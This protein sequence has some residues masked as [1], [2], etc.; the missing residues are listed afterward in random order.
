M[1]IESQDV[2]VS[3][4]Y[5]DG[6]AANWDNL[7]RCSYSERARAYDRYVEHRVRYVTY[8]QTR[9][10]AKYWIIPLKRKQKKLKPKKIDPKAAA[11]GKKSEEFVAPAVATE[12]YISE[13]EWSDWD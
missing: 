5:L 11:E 10:D 1:D 12:D 4:A 7:S 2:M 6:F 3:R 13:D 8:M 9:P